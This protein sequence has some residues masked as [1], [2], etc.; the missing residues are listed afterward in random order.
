MSVEEL[1][2]YLSVTVKKHSVCADGVCSDTLHMLRCL[3]HPSTSLCQGNTV[4]PNIQ[5]HVAAAR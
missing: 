5:V 4:L 2:M 3:N 1:N